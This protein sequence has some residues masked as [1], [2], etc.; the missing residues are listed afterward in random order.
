MVKGAG[1]QV[2]RGLQLGRR[3]AVWRR[4]RINCGVQAALQA[5]ERAQL[6]IG[7]QGAGESAP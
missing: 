2:G 3:V 1:L 6:Q 7:K 5:G 4:R